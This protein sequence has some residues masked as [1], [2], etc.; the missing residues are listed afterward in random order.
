MISHENN[1]I[2]HQCSN[3]DTLYSVK[4]KHIQNIFSPLRLWVIYFSTCENFKWNEMTW[5]FNGALYMKLIVFDI[6]TLLQTEWY[7]SN[8]F[9]I[10]FSITN[11]FFFLVIVLCSKY[12]ICINWWVLLISTMPPLHAWSN[13]IMLLKLGS[14]A[15]SLEDLI[16]LD[17]K[18]GL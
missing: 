16:G 5:D 2:S 8:L 17:Y 13:P 18:I 10:K 1:L 3:L 4:N 14:Y 6:F 12:E 9:V 11:F 15:I 7:I